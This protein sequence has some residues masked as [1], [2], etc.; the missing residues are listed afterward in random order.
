MLGVFKR[1]KICIAD[2]G[3]VYANYEASFHIELCANNA[4]CS[5]AFTVFEF[6]GRA[7]SI[8]SKRIERQPALCIGRHCKAALEHSAVHAAVA[9]GDS[10]AE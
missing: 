5:F 4:A 6:Y 10:S 7:K 2:F 9:S 8:G 1:S 3:G